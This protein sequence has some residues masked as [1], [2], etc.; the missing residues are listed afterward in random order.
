V[1]ASTCEAR[2]LPSPSHTTLVDA[3]CV[4]V[5]AGKQNRNNDAGVAESVRPSFGSSSRSAR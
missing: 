1:A 4:V 3:T 5:P 2:S